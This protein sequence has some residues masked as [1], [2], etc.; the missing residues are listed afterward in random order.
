[1][2]RHI[3]KLIWNRKRTNLLM[4]AEIL[5][6]FLVLFAVTALGVYTADNWRRPIGYS[7]DNVWAIAVDMKQTSDD[8]FTARQQETLTQL[9]LALK[10]SPEIV[11]SA[12]TMLTPYEMGSS[13]SRYSW[14]KRDVEFGVAEVT[15]GFRDVLGLQMVEGRWFSH[16]DDGQAYDAVVINEDMRRE[17]FGNGPAVGQSISPDRSASDTGEPERERRIVGVVAAYREDGEF[18]GSRNYVIYRKNVDGAHGRRDRPPRNILIKVQPGTTAGFQQRLVQ[19]LQGVAPEWSF[20]ITTLDEARDSFNGFAFAPL[21][22]VGLVAAFLMLMVALGLVGV[23]WQNVTQRTREIGLRRA[24]GATR[25]AVRRQI[26]GEIAVM[27]A[28]ALA[29]GTA[30]VVQLPLLDVIYF[31]EPHVY[32]IGLMISL[33]AIFGLTLACGWYPGYLATR[34]EPADALRYE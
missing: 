18:D 32:A 11:H 15:D 25:L 31:V 20:D 8:D 12:G 2:T 22:A 5:V 19:R 30:I 3:L 33:A 13:N 9:L 6:S 29:V 23:L 4:M 28:I 16:D 24:K 27:T 17:M 34:V 10:S 7:I 26:L 1:M 14:H 21:I